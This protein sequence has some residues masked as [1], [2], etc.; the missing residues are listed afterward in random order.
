MKIV[1]CVKLKKRKDLRKKHG[2][3]RKRRKRGEDRREETERKQR[4]TGRGMTAFS[5]LA[6]PF[7]HQCGLQER[8]H[9]A[10]AHPASSA[11]I[12][13]RFPTLRG[14]KSRVSAGD[15]Q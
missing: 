1:D 13:V 3:K 4:E 2:E 10:L 12:N 5:Q 8:A 7:P 9:P 6:C 11:A 15:S 14:E